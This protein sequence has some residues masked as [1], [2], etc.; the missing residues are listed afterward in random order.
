MQGNVWKHKQFY[1]MNK[2]KIGKTLIRQSKIKM[3][4]SKSYSMFE[5]QKKEKCDDL[6]QRLS[7]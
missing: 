1:K 6:A 7:T 3:L 4:F 5:T 2:R